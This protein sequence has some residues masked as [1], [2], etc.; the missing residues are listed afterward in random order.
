MTPTLK[1]IFAAALVTVPAAGAGPGAQPGPPAPAPAPTPAPAPPRPTAPEAPA[2][3]SPR[4]AAPANAAA[5]PA[6]RADGA[7]ALHERIKARIAERLK[8]GPVQVLFIGDSITQG[9]DAVGRSVWDRHFERPPRNAVNMGIGGDRTQHV[10]WRLDPAGG[11]ALEAFK[12]PAPQPRVA[13]LMI[14]TNNCNGTDHTPPEIAAGVESVVLSLRAT[15]PETRVLLLGILP[16][17]RAVDSARLK[18]AEV[19]TLL[20]RLDDHQSGGWVRFADLSDHFL[21]DDGS[22]RPDLMP[23][24]LHLSEKGYQVW[25]DAM[26]RILPAMLGETPP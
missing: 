6:E 16:R 3:L 8:H 10:L 24:G 9:W 5:T 25:A 19:N 20:A 18:A 22:V 14:G 12:P 21:A 15:L 7:R 4:P 1:R 13:V 17:G 26:E 23:D 11:A 2:P